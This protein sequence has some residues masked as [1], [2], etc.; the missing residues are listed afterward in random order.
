MPQ[1]FQYLVD[2]NSIIWQVGANTDGTLQT[3][4]V[5]SIPSGSAA[6]ATKTVQ[7]VVNAVSQDVR[8]VLSNSG[9]DA[10]ILTDYVNR[11]SLKILRQTNWQYLISAPQHFMTRLGVT[12][13][14]IGA[15]GTGPIGSFDTSLNLTDLR[16]IKP[17]TVYDRTNLTVTGRY[18]DEPLSSSFADK[19]NIPTLGVPRNFKI[20]LDNPFLLSLFPAPNNQNSFQPVPNPPLCITT[21]GGAL[22]KRTYYVKITLVD[23]NGGESAVN[24]AETAIFVPASSLLVVK[25]PV[26]SFSAADSGIQ[27]TGY[28]VYASSTSRSE[29][30][31]NGGTAITLGSDFT[32]SVGGLS[33]GTSSA[34]T[35]ST[36]AP[37]GGYLI[38]FRYFKKRTQ[39]SSLGQTIQIPDDFFDV[40]VAGVNWLAYSY[41]KRQDD[42]MMWRATFNEGLRE[43]IRDKNLIP[44]AT[45]DYMRPDVTGLTGRSVPLNSNGGF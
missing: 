17:G 23:S 44:N 1:I 2:S 9:S 11:I 21:S 36:I 26:F 5:G 43:M 15:T 10:S 22:A 16:S 40:V 3:T 37:M 24:T 7:D 18:D 32:E 42:A 20:T 27:Y 33:T 14:W 35:N 6:F 29:C 38:E 45:S 8:Q 4:Q 28:K 25:S 19:G 34:P 41:L 39:L 13:Y 30:V 31:Q 12:D